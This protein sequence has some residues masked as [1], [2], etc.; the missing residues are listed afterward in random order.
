MFI[1][2]SLGGVK[3]VSRGVGCV[4]GNVGL[5]VLFVVVIM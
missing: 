5:I 2:V 1:V 4:L 3:G